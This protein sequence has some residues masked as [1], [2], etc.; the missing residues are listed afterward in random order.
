[1]D[2][3][4]R[5]HIVQKRKCVGTKVSHCEIAESRPEMSQS[6]DR[7]VIE[8][9]LVIGAESPERR[10]GTVTAVLTLPRE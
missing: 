3:G 4:K 1:M 10:N 7:G 9:G 5:K 2:R 8:H 6:V